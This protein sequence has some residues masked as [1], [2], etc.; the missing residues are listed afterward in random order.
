MKLAP[1]VLLAYR[2]AD[3]LR[4]VLEAIQKNPLAEHSDLIV[5]SDGPKSV[6]NK[7]EVA[8]INAVRELVKSKSWCKN[9]KLVASPV[10]K[11]VNENFFD[12]ISEVM[13]QYGK[14]IVIEDDIVVS[15]YFL[16]Y[17]NDALNLYE[18]EK[19]VFHITGYIF[20]MKTGKLGDTYF[21]GI[22]NTWGW[23]TWKDRWDK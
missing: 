3:H 15:P 23:A 13:N 17:M 19:K 22:P 21:L 16:E 20:N 2:R 10:N 18:N 1:I 5:Y 11:G 12:S 7:E 6:H 8:G 9:V 14:A 4:K